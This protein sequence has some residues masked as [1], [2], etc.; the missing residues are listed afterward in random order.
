MAG[1]H[2]AFSWEP[3]HQR[4][5]DDLRARL[6]STDA[7]HTPD[8]DKPF[9]VWADA[10]D[11]ACGGMLLQ[12]D[13]A[14]VPRVIEYFS[15]KFTVPESKYTTPEREALGLMLATKR[16]RKYLLTSNKFAVALITDH[17]GLTY[18]H[19]NTDSSSRL[20][21]WAQSLWEFNY[22]IRW[23]PGSEQEAADALSRLTSWVT[24]TVNMI[25]ASPAR[26]MTATVLNNQV[27]DIDR[28]VTEHRVGRQIHYRVHWKGYS[29]DDDTIE[30]L[31]SLRKQMSAPQLLDLRDK[32]EQRT[33]KEAD[34]ELPQLDHAPPLYHHGWRGQTAHIDSQDPIEA[35]H[36]MDQQLGY[37]APSEHPCHNDEFI[38]EAL[39]TTKLLPEL[40][41]EH[42]IKQQRRDEDLC[43]RMKESTSIDGR[44]FKHASG[45]WCKWYT[46]KVGPR[47]GHDLTVVALPESLV[48]LA[49]ASVHDLAG[50]H[51]GASTLF[52]MQSRFAFPRLY[53]RTIDYVKGCETCGRAKRDKRPVPLG[54][55]PVYGFLH[56]VGIDF[57]GPF[58][59]TPSGNKYLAIVV[60]HATKWTHVVPTKS[61][62]TNDAS[63]ALMDFVQ[64]YGM[65]QQVVSD[66][67][68]SFT[69]T[70]W[71]QLMKKLQVKHAPTLSYNPQGDS[72][73]E[74][75]VGNIKSIIKIVTQRHPR[76][77]DEAAR[78]AAWSYNNSYHSTLGTSP[79][80][81]RH[82]REPRHLSDV[83]FQHPAAD[84]P[85]TLSELV[86]RVNDV[87][88]QT[89]ANIEQLH[90]AVEAKNKSINRARKFSEGDRVWLDRV[91]PGAA[92]PA[93]N[94]LTRA[95]FWPY[96]PEL[97]VITRLC[98]EQHACIELAA[99]DG[100]D[101]QHQTVHLRRLKPYL[102]SVDAYNY[103]DMDLLT[104]PD[105][106]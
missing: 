44:Y 55:I 65:F 32:F 11:K 9:E 33:T 24:A 103:G 102:P 30:S 64:H 61:T 49:L 14:G 93:A 18:L 59:E 77:W 62:S 22:D 5:F 23:V 70:A 85:V 71:K 43:K 25:K 27:F 81:A 79:F 48:P 74:A 34:L 73:A 16:F 19:R 100:D 75:S 46:P 98:S 35:E 90:A 47:K 92:S 13:D 57:A 67:G 72:H 29:H 20:Y 56:T 78:W 105:P 3:V 38:A 4:A 28:L 36:A 39:P 26:T 17:K 99:P 8:W 50:H 53:T 86:Q 60:D 89:Q 87:H 63:F 58:A 31:A 37:S 82:G 2:Q 83:I 94:G 7:L 66:R 88:R 10:S 6:K 42:L 106:S 15:H 69:S 91:Y 104:T 80:F 54:K 96:R 1:D 51:G 84:D 76:H 45:V 12:R 40:T 97:Y 95:W 101:K 52:H 41:V 68:S 21:R